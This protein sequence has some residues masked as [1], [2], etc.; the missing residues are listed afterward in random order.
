MSGLAPSFYFLAASRILIGVGE[1]S[2]VTAAPGY[3]K[4]RIQD[5]AKVNAAL[6]IFFAA[7]PV[8]AAFGYILGGSMVGPFGWRAAFFTAGV[9]GIILSSLFLCLK[10]VRP[11]VSPQ[12]S[13]ESIVLQVRAILSIPAIRYALIGYTLNSFALNG[14]ATFMVPLGVAKGF[15][16][17]VVGSTF[18]VILVISGFIGTI[19]GGKL[20]SFFAVRSSDPIATMLKFIGVMSLISAP[21]FAAAFSGAGGNSFYISCFTAELI[22]FAVIAP[23]NSI[24]V[25]TSPAQSVTLM[26]GIT[27]LLL[28]LFGAFSAPILIGAVAD[29]IG[30]E[31][32]LHLA[33][34]ALLGSGLV[35]L[36]G[37]QAMRNT[38]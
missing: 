5:P 7:I 28:N 22:I 38:R 21:L 14:V 11:V 33:T 20:T 9:P 1:A 13:S 34:I 31:F 37:A 16:A 25:L 27:V 10:E 29:K 4:D 19:G 32:A 30:L 3:I 6:A 23:V 18:G 12:A 2:F 35:W 36:R 24:L 26:Q 17:G 8:G 15:E